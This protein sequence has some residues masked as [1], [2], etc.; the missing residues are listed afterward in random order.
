[1]RTLLI[2]PLL[3]LTLGG[4]SAAD[5]KLLTAGAFKSAAVELVPAF[6]REIGHKVIIDNDT[7]GGLAKRIAGG[8]AFD[9]VVL[10]PALSLALAFRRGG[11]EPGMRALV[12]GDGFAARYARAVAFTVGCRVQSLAARE[13]EAPGNRR[14]DILIE[15]SGDPQNL[16]WALRT[17]P[18]WGTVYSVGGAL[19]SS[20]LDYY[21]HVHRRA[22]A[23]THVPER[24]APL[25]GEEQI[26]E[27][28]ATQLASVLAGI[29]P[30]QDEELKAG[31]QA[32]EW[33]VRLRRERGGWALLRVDGP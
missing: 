17:C 28:G 13:E 6:E 31:V 9:V 10:P 4:A 2:I 19:T 22:L 11:T 32:D 5:L 8:E 30:D 24:P 23:L 27:R 25:Q 33:S 12:I 3:L 16:E 18:D 21:A 29:T 20:P 15:T 26:L 7:A 1:M 14:P